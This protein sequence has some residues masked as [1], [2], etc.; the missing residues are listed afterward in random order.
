[1]LTMSGE[2]PVKGWGERA[3]GGLGRE[4]AVLRREGGWGPGPSAGGGERTS[5]L[6]ERVDTV[7]GA[8]VRRVRPAA[9]HCPALRRRDSP[10]TTTVYGHSRHTSPRPSPATPPHLP[11]S[12]SLPNHACDPP[13]T[14]R[15]ATT[16]SHAAASPSAAARPCCSHTLCPPCSRWGGVGLNS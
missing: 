14:P 12:I 1:M 16:S 4:N 15:S 3:D 13:F 10:I 5:I 9:S 11:S 8:R 6:R 2:K 7:G